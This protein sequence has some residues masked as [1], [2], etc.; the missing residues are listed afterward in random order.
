MRPLIHNILLAAL[1][2][3]IWAGAAFTADLSKGE[4][5]IKLEA[6]PDKV[7]PAADVML[8]FT[9]EAP[10]A[11]KVS[12]PDLQ[13]RFSG[14]TKA[15]DFATDPIEANGRTRQTF[16]W[17]LVPEPG[18]E[19]YRL[20]PFAV[21]VMDT[22]VVPAKTDTFATAPVVFPGEGERPAVT[23]APEVDVKPEWIPPTAKTVTLWG[24]AV[25][26]GLAALA[27]LIW[28]LTRITVRVKEFR[29]S[30]VD[31][32]MAELQRLLSRNLPQRGLY[33]EFYIELTQVVRRYIERRHGIR[34]P[35]QTT[36]EFLLAASRH[37]SFTPEVISS[38]RKF[39]ESADLVKF[40]GQEATVSTADQATLSAKA[41]LTE[42]NAQPVQKEAK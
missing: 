32:A 16:R 36:E 34:A 3:P 11:L 38:L 39:L 42:D 9:V 20:A 10:S 21:S 40:A 7:S 37:P 33:K 24:L 14:F 4:V 2:F 6:T 25:L 22:R 12:F 28:G 27:A 15:E 1:L 8:T 29:M 23:G 18:A 17:R 31:R 19:R 13:N 35:E 41:Y 30:P 26:G 5:S